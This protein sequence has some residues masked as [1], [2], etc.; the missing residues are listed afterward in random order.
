MPL[1]LAWQSAGEAPNDDYG[2]KC[3]WAGDVNG[4]GNDDF[5]VAAPGHDSNKGRL[6]LYYGSPKGLAEAPGW[7]A[8][9]EHAIDGFSK[10][11]GGAGDLN[12]DGFDDIYAASPDYG[13]L[14]RG[15]GALYV[16]YGGPNG[17]SKSPDWAKNGRVVDEIF[18]DCSSSHERRNSDSR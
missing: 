13:Q 2:Y 4:D 6:Y 14:V 12:G 11:M 10:S 15:Q 3:A 17:P 1:Q 18:G 8:D 5:L 16:Y 9:G 7:T